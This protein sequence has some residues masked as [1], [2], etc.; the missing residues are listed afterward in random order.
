MKGQVANLAHGTP[1]A[2]PVPA[3]IM[4]GM[5]RP[6][7]SARGTVGGSGRGNTPRGC[8]WLALG[9]LVASPGF[10]TSSSKTAAAAV[11]Q[12]CC[13]CC[14][15]NIQG[16]ARWE[17]G[18]SPWAGVQ[19]ICPSS[20]GQ[21]VVFPCQTHPHHTHLTYS[22]TLHNAKKQNGCLRSL[23]N[24]C[25]KKR[26]EKKRRKGKI[27]PFALPQRRVVWMWFGAFP[28]AFGLG[29]AQPQRRGTSP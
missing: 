3:C 21:H 28:G 23:T 9:V 22:Y 6:P 10:A 24:S 18:P 17:P 19:V 11:P 26:S 1:D 5:A 13:D 27:Y 15:K 29:R 12:L 25:E 16:D 20:T 14:G 4:G 2:A 8:D 7:C